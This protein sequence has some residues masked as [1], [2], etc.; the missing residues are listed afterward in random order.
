[1]PF[2]MRSST[3]VQEMLLRRFP[4][5][6]YMKRQLIGMLYGGGYRHMKHMQR[7]QQGALPLRRPA[8]PPASA[9]ACSS[10]KSSVRYC[11]KPY[12]VLCRT[13]LRWP[14]C[15][16]R[17]VSDHVLDQYL[18]TSSGTPVYLRLILSASR[19]GIECRCVV[20]RLCRRTK[21]SLIPWLTSGQASA[22]WTSCRT[23]KPSAAAHW[24]YLMASC[25]P[26]YATLS[27]SSCIVLQA[28]RH[29][30]LLGLCLLR[31]QTVLHSLLWERRLAKDPSQLCPCFCRGT[32]REAFGTPWSSVR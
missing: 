18:F 26:W 19:Q 1:M 11:P 27:H 2:L 30:C 31:P 15:Q 28:I 20:T 7:L 29:R 24:I 12:G 4:L 9:S 16:A 14:A 6:W 25:P 5:I 32:W 21:T 13:A 3:I 23:W 22:A 8:G 10:P 17:S